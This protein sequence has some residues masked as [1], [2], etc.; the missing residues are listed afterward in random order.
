MNTISASARLNYMI[1]TYLAYR[2]LE[3]SAN[4]AVALH[5]KEIQWSIQN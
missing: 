2:Y 5:I 4:Y 3:S 1:S